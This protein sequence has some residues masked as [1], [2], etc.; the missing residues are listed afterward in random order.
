VTSEPARS[1]VYEKFGQGS[2]TAGNLA[3]QIC[4]DAVRIYE[5]A[6]SGETTRI[7]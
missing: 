7:M 2:F 3:V 4:A 6:Q 5:I 1:A